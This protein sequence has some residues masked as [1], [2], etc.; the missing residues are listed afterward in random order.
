M[1]FFNGIISY[2]YF[3]AQEKK[4]LYSICTMLLHLHTILYIKDCSSTNNNKPQLNHVNSKQ[5]G[6][7]ESQQKQTQQNRTNNVQLLPLL[8]VVKPEDVVKNIEAALR[9]WHQMEH[10]HTTKHTSD[11]KF[12]SIPSIQ[13]KSLSLLF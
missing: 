10:L 11:Y 6:S 2:F 8:S 12:Y 7:R 9:C 13:H 5:I 3:I 1:S 4:L